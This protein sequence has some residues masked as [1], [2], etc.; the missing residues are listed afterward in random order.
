[1]HNISKKKKKKPTMHNDKMQAIYIIHNR[2]GQAVQ[3][4]GKRANP[5]AWFL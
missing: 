5:Q 3:I 2:L 4:T 1:M